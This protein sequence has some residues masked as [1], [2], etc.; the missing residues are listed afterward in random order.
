MRDIFIGL[1]GNKSV[2]YEIK[3]QVTQVS[4]RKGILKDFGGDCHNQYDS[5]RFD[6][7]CRSRYARHK[8]HKDWRI[9]VKSLD[10]KA[11]KRHMARLDQVADRLVDSFDDVYDPAN[12]FFPEWE[13]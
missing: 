6:N 12:F 10:R 9:S 3:V 8:C 1:E 5:H 4:M 13:D 11:M 7:Y 2:V